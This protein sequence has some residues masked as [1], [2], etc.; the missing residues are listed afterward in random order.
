MV[1]FLLSWGFFWGGGG[2]Y[3]TWCLYCYNF[4]AALPKCTVCVY[5]H[6]CVW[7]YRTFHQGHVVRFLQSVSSVKFMICCSF[8]ISL[9]TVV[10]FLC[11]LLDHRH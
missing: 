8:L 5:E 7:L 9:E 4:W 6:F 1:L 11:M 10:M 2:L 3:K